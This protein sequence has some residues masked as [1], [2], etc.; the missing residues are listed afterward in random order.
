MWPLISI[1]KLPLVL[2]SNA[3]KLFV[4]VLSIRIAEFE[5]IPVGR[6]INGNIAYE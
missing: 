5:V 2:F 4:N 3:A 1:T 6:L